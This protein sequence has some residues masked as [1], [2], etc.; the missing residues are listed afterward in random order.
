MA[1]L[2]SVE[3]YSCDLNPWQADMQHQTIIGIDESFSKRWT[4][5]EVIMD[6]PVLIVTPPISPTS[7]ATSWQ[8]FKSCEATH[9]TTTKGSVGMHEIGAASVYEKAWESQWEREQ[10]LQ[11][12][13]AMTCF[14]AKL[15]DGSGIAIRQR[16]VL[17]R[18]CFLNYSTTSSRLSWRRASLELLQLAAV[19]RSGCTVKLTSSQMSWLGKAQSVKLV[20]DS[21]LEAV[22]LEL[23]LTQLIAGAAKAARQSL[24]RQ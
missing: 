5:L 11:E 20:L 12:L 17:G 8:S 18:R 13:K 6:K 2:L 16:G 7:S 14:A 15:I 4:T 3:D 22:M 19:R 10:A 24:L 1:H 9:S 21:E 23:L